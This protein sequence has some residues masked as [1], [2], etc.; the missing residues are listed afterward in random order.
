ML[1]DAARVATRVATSSEQLPR[2]EW[3]ED[4]FVGHLINGYASGDQWARAG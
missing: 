4:R 3:G 2:H 1:V